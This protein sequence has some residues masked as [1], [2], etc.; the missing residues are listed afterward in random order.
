MARL[1]I[2]AVAIALFFLETEFSLFSPIEFSGE[3]YYLVPRFLILYLIFLSIYYDRKKAM[4]YGLAFGVLNDIVY[5]DI[6][7]LYTFLYPFICFIAGS[8]VKYIHQHLVVTTTLSLL[9]VALLEI[10]LHQFF[11]LI[12]YTD[13]GFAEFLNQR[14]VPTMI[15]NSIYL[16]MLGWTFKY[17]LEARVLEKANQSIL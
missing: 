5:I 10:L 6:I 2:P 4:W 8:T 13:I 9:L 16:I 1:L 12:G 3:N 14:L 11:F 15:A 17:L 7:G